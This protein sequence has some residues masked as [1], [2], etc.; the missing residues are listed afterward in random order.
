[1][2]RLFLTSSCR[3]SFELGQVQVNVNEVPFDLSKIATFLGVLVKS[4][5]PGFSSSA[6]NVFS[7]RTCPCSATGRLWGAAAQSRT[8]CCQRRRRRR[9]MAVSRRCCRCRTACLGC[10]QRQTPACAC[11]PCHNLGTAEERN[12]RVFMQRTV[13]RIIIACP[14]KPEQYC[15][16]SNYQPPDLKTASLQEYAR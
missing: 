13:F 2:Q 10:Q 8:W 4:L 5:L 14:A 11:G 12:A 3:C 1:M 7:V 15:I 9:M 16:L 6:Q